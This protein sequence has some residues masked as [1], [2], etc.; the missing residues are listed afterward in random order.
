M[1]NNGSHQDSC[2]SNYVNQ[3]WIDTMSKRVDYRTLEANLESWESSRSQI[4][5]P[6]LKKKLQKFAFEAWTIWPQFRVAFVIPRTSQQDQV[7][8]KVKK[9]PT[10]HT[11]EKEQ[12]PI[13]TN[14]KK[15]ENTFLLAW[16]TAV[17]ADAS[18]VFVSPYFLET[19]KGRFKLLTTFTLRLV[20]TWSFG[21]F[22]MLHRSISN[23]MK[24]TSVRRTFRI[25][26]CRSF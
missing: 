2:T 14:W 26:Y 7:R 20:L 11:Q 6:T 1:W 8:E 16:P 24:S 3:L 17:P 5:F 23:S 10:A 18:G 25:S 15:K 13:D 9:T 4:Y 21:R 19:T 22:I 12:A